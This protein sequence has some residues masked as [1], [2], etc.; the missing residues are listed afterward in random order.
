[1]G[2][3]IERALRRAEYWPVV[4]PLATQA[5]VS[6]GMPALRPVAEQIAA[7]NVAWEKWQV[8]HPL[9]QLPAD[10]ANP[11][12]RSAEVEAQFRASMQQLA[13]SRERVSDAE[14]E[15]A[16][17]TA[18]AEAELPR[19]ADEERYVKAE[20]DALKYNSR[21]NDGIERNADLGA[22]VVAVR[23]D[24]RPVWASAVDVARSM[25]AEHQQAE[26]TSVTENVQ[27]HDAGIER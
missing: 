23:E 27:S 4:G 5:L 22:E 18:K 1:M 24:T 19:G 25:A 14:L 17:A 6:M 13:A 15:A 9:E 8:D 3:L 12:D 26:R 2:D 11:Q 7:A 10:L 20:R 21:H 16:A